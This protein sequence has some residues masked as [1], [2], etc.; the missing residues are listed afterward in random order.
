MALADIFW[1]GFRAQLIG[2]EFVSDN[3]D[4]E[5][6]LNQTAAYRH[7]KEYEYYPLPEMRLLDRVKRSIPGATV[8]LL[9]PI[10]SEPGVIY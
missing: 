2:R 7:P 10:P 9:I 3:K 6:L 8:N 5:I 4:F 1:K